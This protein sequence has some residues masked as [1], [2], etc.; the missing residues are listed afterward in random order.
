MKVITCTSL[1]LLLF[2]GA[3]R[4]EV[5]PNRWIA[6]FEDGV[7][8]PE[9]LAERAALAAGAERGAVW[10]HALE[11]F[12]FGGSTQAAAA[13]ARSP[14]VAFVEP[15]R[16]V[17][18]FCHT[19]GQEVPAGIARIGATANATAAID[20]LVG[21]VD[22]DIAILDTGVYR[23]GDLNEEGGKHWNCASNKGCAAVSTP[24][25]DNGHG[26]HV[27]GTAAAIDD[28]SGVV[29]AA[30]GAR[31]W[32]I[33]VLDRNGKGAWSWVIN[34]LNLV[35][36][37][38]AAIDVA[39]LSLGGASAENPSSC[40][41]SSLHKA[42]CGVTNAG[43][44]VVAAAG[45][46]AVDAGG[47]VPAKYDEVITVSA[48]DAATDAFATFSNF[49]AAV[50]LAAP[51][52]GILSTWPGDRRSSWGYCAIA[53]GTSMAA[54]HVTGG[55]ALFVARYGR[56]CDRNGR[57]DGADPTCIRDYLIT[58]GHCP[59]GGSPDPPSGHCLSTWPGDPDGLAEPLLYVA[60]PW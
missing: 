23:H 28:A 34:G 43:V 13:V 35:A 19:G 45:N 50:D 49:G 20:G 14:R 39:N 40:M 36:A 30:P 47:S 53:D 5:I 24:K 11:G 16:T 21:R 2:A 56:D 3:A 15:D 26:T 8:D 10:R 48:M 38:A 29:G 9:G 7:P 51:G 25:D 54:P 1:C 22:A 18:A 12:T 46:E 32:S 58:R 6:V 17:S 52:V 33:K 60:E 37:Q 31:L 59:D 42:I 41:S 44:T 4:A 57:V 27:A 55:V